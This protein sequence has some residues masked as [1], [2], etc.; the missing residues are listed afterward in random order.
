MDSL[1][2]PIDLFFFAV[3][4][5]CFYVCPFSTATDVTP[6]YANRSF[7]DPWTSLST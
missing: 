1:Y 2:G 6:M 3:T 4:L 7:S 5:L